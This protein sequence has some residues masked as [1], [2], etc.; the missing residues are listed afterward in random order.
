MQELGF[1]LNR[2]ITC[3]GEN[4]VELDMDADVDEVVDKDESVRE[5][6]L[7]KENSSELE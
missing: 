2:Q 7:R 3:G 1:R 5:S 4:M 6:A